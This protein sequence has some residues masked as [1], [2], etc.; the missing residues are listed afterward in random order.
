MENIVVNTFGNSKPTVTNVDIVPVQFNW[1]EK[2]TMIDLIYTPYLFSDIENL[3]IVA[4]NYPLLKNLALSG[5]K[6]TKG[7]SR[8]DI[9]IGADNYESII[10]GKTHETVTAKSSL[11]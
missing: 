7:K 2:T 5:Y 4:E 8:I 9:L 10:R 1:G 3:K 6:F 11:G